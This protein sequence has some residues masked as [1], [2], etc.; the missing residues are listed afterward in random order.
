MVRAKQVCCYRVRIACNPE[1]IETLLAALAEARASRT[2]WT[3]AQWAAVVDKIKRSRQWTSFSHGGGRRPLSWK[4]K[5]A[6]KP[7]AAKPAPA[8]ATASGDAVVQARSPVIPLALTAGDEAV[9]PVVDDTFPRAAVEVASSAGDRR[10]GVLD[11]IAKGSYGRVYK[12]VHKKT[13]TPLRSRL[14]I[15]AASWRRFRSEGWQP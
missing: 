11:F 4:V 14:S 15:L 10:F 9:V 12:A 3:Q 8:K 5:A 2:S 13:G 6:A 1:L 7:A